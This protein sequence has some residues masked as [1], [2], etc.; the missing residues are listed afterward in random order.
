MRVRA[1]SSGWSGGPGLNTFYFIAASGGGALVS[2]SAQL[3]H[4]R[5]RNAFY[6]ARAAWP[7]SWTLAMQDNV[8]CL[9]PVNG[10]LVDS[11]ATTPIA[12]VTGTAAGGFGPIAAAILLRLQ[13]SIFSDGRRIQ[14][15]AFLGPVV[16]STDTNGTPAPA[17]IT[18][19]TA[20]ATAL[21]DAGLW[22][23]YP[24]VVVW[25]R[26]RLADA[27]RTPAVTARDG[28]YAEVTSSSVPDK[29]AVLRSRRD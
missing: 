21:A 25:R 1:V 5:V 15:R 11:V 4:D 28:M 24:R 26:P 9:D 10:D 18:A 23:S 19:G 8:D 3:A 17:L 2:G 27:L 22:T 7:T 16:N 14:G 13:T 6:D 29:Y 12:G 20:F